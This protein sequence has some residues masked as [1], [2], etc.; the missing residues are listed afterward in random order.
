MQ[1][2]TN[3]NKWPLKELAFVWGG[4]I[5]SK[6]MMFA[7]TIY[8]ANQ[9]EVEGFGVFSTAFSIV[10]Y[11]S[12]ALFTGLDTLTTRESAS[13]CPENAWTFSKKLFS[14]RSKLVNLAVVATALFAFFMGRENREM[15]FTLLLFGLSF[16]FQQ[17]YSVN[18]F[19]GLEWPGP[20]AAYFIGGRA[21][22]LFLLFLF[23]KGPENIFWAAGAFTIAIAVEN[24][25][26][27]FCLFSRFRKRE[28]LSLKVP[29]IK[30]KPALLLTLLTALLLL[31]ENAPQFLVYLLKG[32]GEAGLYASSFR[33]IY[34]AVTFANLGGFVF[35]ARFI[36]QSGKSEETVRVSYKKARYSALLLGVA[37]AAAGYFLS[38]F[39]YDILFKTS[40]QDGVQILKAGIFQMALVPARVLAWQYCIARGKAEKLLWPLLIGVFLSVGISFCCISASGAIGAAR[41]LVCG[42]AIITLFMLFLAG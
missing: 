26:L 25:F 31:H 5:L 8:L 34:T 29:E 37:F 1:G 14:F 30:L 10:N 23:V 42:E 16:L 15:G 3:V 36:K 28:E 2:P 41:G 20:I 22:Y 27:F 13:L 24:L 4:N 38:G 6:V 40:Y 17:I 21:V 18:L 35:L 19:Y 33:L 11:I 39:V 32:E 7:A 12:L 9:L